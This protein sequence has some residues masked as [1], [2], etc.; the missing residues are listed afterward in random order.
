VTDATQP[1]LRLWDDNP[2]LIDLLG[3]DA[4]VNP[5][6]EAIETP[7][8]DPVTIG[9]QS[10]WGGGKSTVINLLETALSKDPDCV[11]VRTDPWQYDNHDDVRGVLI[12]EILDALR[13]AFD[14]NGDI[15]KRIDELLRRIS[16]SRVALALGRGAAG[17]GWSPEQLANAFTP[18]KRSEPDSMS[19]FKAAF[20]EMMALLP[21]TTQRVVILIDDLDRCLPPAVM[22]TLEAIKLFLAV[23]KMVFVLAADQDLIHDAVSAH[24]SGTNRSQAFARRYLEKIVQ[25]P[26]SLPRLSEDDAETYIALLLA[27]REA[28]DSAAFAAVAAHAAARRGANTWPLLSEWPDGTWQPSTETVLLARQLR[29]GLAADRL[30]SPRQIKRF[31][32]AY[33]V[34][35]AI[36]GGRGVTIPAPVVVKM[37]LLEDRHRQA[38]EVLA[39]WPANERQANIEQWEQWAAGEGLAC[40]EGIDETTREWAAAEPSLQG[41]DLTPYLRL[42]ASLVNVPLGGSVSDTVVALVQDLLSDSEPTRMA[43]LLTAAG[44]GPAEQ[45]SA[46]ALLIDNGLA[47]E[48]SNVMWVSAIR[49]ARESPVVVDQV[50]SAVKDH[51]GRLTMAVPAE[52]AVPGVEALSLLVPWIAESAAVPDDVAEAARVEIES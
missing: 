15:T 36:A 39:G 6:L 7:H 44:L 13:T 8:L 43:A 45:V 50:A 3:F 27:E 21:K 2:S 1:G 17:L 26:I 10:P 11:V 29:E 37:L 25:L 38:F 16:W 52:L 47:V 40:P 49:W 51:P 30:S 31:L 34:R 22:G 28:P 32:N 5:V 41:L 14:S 20:A 9:V 48:D 19:G 46:M 12:A 35:S 18:R 23:P 33:G 4:V 42:A 24:L